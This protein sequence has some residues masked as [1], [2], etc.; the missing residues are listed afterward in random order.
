MEVLGLEEVN[1]IHTKNQ[2]MSYQPTVYINNKDNTSRF[3][4][5][6][7]GVKPLIV[8]GINP[9]T[10]D[11]KERDQ[12]IKKV[13]G[14]ADGNGFDSFIMLN[15]YPQRAIDTT[16][17]HSSID[18]EIHK[19]NLETISSILQQQNSPTILAAWSEKIAE[20]IYLKECLKAIF[21][22]TK[23]SKINWIKLG[24]F[25]KSGHPRHPSRASYSLALTNIDIENYIEKLR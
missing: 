19:K 10:A 4:L 21:E 16:L 3:A 7:E 24:N 12:T 15:L 13:M 11:D 5:G 14:F 25:T 1:S 8:I 17:L 20:R 6:T 9:S 2:P 18:I 23:E 22:T